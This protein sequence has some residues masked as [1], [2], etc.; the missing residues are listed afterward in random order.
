MHRCA[1][2]IAFQHSGWKFG[3]ETT[4]AWQKDKLVVAHCQPLLETCDGQR[5]CDAVAAAATLQVM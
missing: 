2:R 3:R 5:K 1:C 4:Y